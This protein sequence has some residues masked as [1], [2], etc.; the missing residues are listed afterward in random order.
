ME[1]ARD[2][3]AAPQVQESPQAG[4]RARLKFLAQDAGD[5]PSRIPHGLGGQLLLA[6][7]EVVVG[8][9]ERRLGVFGHLADARGVQAAPADE[10][11]RTGHD[12]IA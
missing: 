3:D 7:G 9:A 4:D 2:D 10:V 6:L 1:F 5:R 11:G 8:R 12:A